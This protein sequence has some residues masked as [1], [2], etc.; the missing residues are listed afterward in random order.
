MRWRTGTPESAGISSRALLKWVE[1]LDQYE[2]VHSFMLIRNGIEAASGWWAPF[3]PH[4]PH[5]LFSLSKSF[6]S[7]AA[8]FAIAE[9][10]FALSTPVLEIFPEYRKFI[11]DSRF[12]QMT[13]R[14]LLTMST[15]HGV[16]STAFFKL[17]PDG[18]LVRDFFTSPLE[19]APG[20]RFVYNSGATFMLSAAL[21]RTTG[22][23]PSRYLRP[24]MLD[25]LDIGERFWEKSPDGTDFGGWGY[26][27]T[28]EEI[29]SFALMLLEQGRVNGVRILPEDY[30][31]E[32]VRQQ[33]STET[34]ANANA[35]W[36]QGYG[37]QF[38][39][40]RHNAFRA[41]GACGQYALV[42]PEQ[43]MVLAVTA[44]GRNMQQILDT[45]WDILLPGVA[46]APLPE[47]PE[48][49]QRLSEKLAGL[50]L[51]V[52]HGE[53]PRK[54]KELIIELASNQESLTHIAIALHPESCTL[55]F[56]RSGMPD[57]VIRAGWEKPLAGETALEDHEN[58]PVSATAKLCGSTLQVRCIFFST[59]FISDYRFTFEGNHVRL[60]RKR[61]LSF[62]YSPLEDFEGTLILPDGKN[63]NE[64]H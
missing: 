38:W 33:I 44:G 8:G 24:R 29:A 34:P 1:A 43:N 46:A 31:Q 27:L 20:E 26:R 21:R 50:A 64:I 51:P 54:K 63:S 41:D 19:Y 5:L 22:E 62:R 18:D 39:R 14:H 10:R 35:D 28:T 4:T 2:H 36:R 57:E 12:E 25:A 17:V 32:S 53:A 15:G 55:T 45:V 3:D 61:N 48:N 9:K 23:N 11:T 40:C 59:P 13:I 52:L 56:K 7:C 16:C 6:I 37:Y 58:R 49:R 42:M 60:N 47:D 30:F